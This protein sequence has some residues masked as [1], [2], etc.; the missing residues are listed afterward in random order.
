MSN[1]PIFVVNTDEVRDGISQRGF[2][3]NVSNIYHL[4]DWILDYL[5]IAEECPEGYRPLAIHIV[6]YSVIDGKVVYWAFA[7]Q[8]APAVYI[9]F[10]ITQD[11]FI[12]RDGENDRTVSIIKTIIGKIISTFNQPHLDMIMSPAS[13]QFPAVINGEFVW[14]VEMKGDNNVDVDNLANQLGTVLGR[15]SQDDITSGVVEMDWLSSKVATYSHDHPA[16][17]DTLEH[18]Q[19]TDNETE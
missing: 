11:D 16:V 12:A 5:D 8:S 19:R 9:S 17:N 18:Q 6:P 1:F 13:F 14:A 2:N 10:R 7:T 15:V 3:W 4:D